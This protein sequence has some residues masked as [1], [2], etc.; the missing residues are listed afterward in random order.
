MEVEGKIL[1]MQVQALTRTLVTLDWP[2]ESQHKLN[3]KSESHLVLLS[4]PLYQKVN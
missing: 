3:K 4:L 2:V 1:R